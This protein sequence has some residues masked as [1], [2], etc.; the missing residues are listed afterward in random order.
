MYFIVNQD[1][2]AIFRIKLIIYKVDTSNKLFVYLLYYFI[3]HLIL[4]YDNIFW[5][6]RVGSFMYTYT[7][8]G[9]WILFGHV[10]K[11]FNQNFKKNSRICNIMSIST[12]CV[13]LFFS[14]LGVLKK[15][16][17]IFL[18]LLLVFNVL[19]GRKQH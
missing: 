1:F 8:Q 16:I 9:Y 6:L 11:L 15:S 7:N 2:T 18:Y 17:T 10:T 5:S 12:I 14:I 3:S 19:I 13:L 4:K